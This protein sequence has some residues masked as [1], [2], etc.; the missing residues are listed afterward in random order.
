MTNMTPYK[1]GIIREVIANAV[2]VTFHCLE[3]GKNWYGSEFSGQGGAGGRGASR[4]EVEARY[5]Y[6]MYSCL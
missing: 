4:N 2:A 1:N 3:K 6:K 5:C